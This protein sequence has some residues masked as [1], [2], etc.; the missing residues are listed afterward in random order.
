[1]DTKTMPLPTGA[2]IKRARE[3]RA[4]SILELAKRAGIT[5]ETL[6]DIETGKRKAHAATIR[7]IVEAL[8]Q[9]P[10]LP[11]IGAPGAKEEQP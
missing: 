9:V 6:N 2:E 4:L 8:N 1:M 11:D 10:T 3:D 7:K 5:W